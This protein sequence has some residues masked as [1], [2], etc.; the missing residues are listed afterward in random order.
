MLLTSSDN[1]TDIQ[2]GGAFATVQEQQDVVPAPLTDIS[3][4]INNEG[5]EGKEKEDGVDEASSEE[6]RSSDEVSGAGSD[7]E[8]YDVAK[9]NSPSSSIKSS[10]SSSE[11][12]SKSNEN[13]SNSGTQLE[14]VE[15]G[16]DI[17]L[18]Q[19]P[20]QL[21]SQPV[22]QKYEYKPIS[23]IELHFSDEGIE[24][25]FELNAHHH[26]YKMISEKDSLHLHYTLNNWLESNDVACAIDNHTG[27]YTFNIPGRSDQ[28]EFAMYATS[29]IDGHR[30]WLTEHGDNMIVNLN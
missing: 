4:I 14:V 8:E 21:K 24:G 2:F 22:K 28:L 27:E 3:N 6:R 17:Q 18:A 23:W 12:E 10:T 20:I 25:R 30:K 11:S 1:S 5:S 15:S 7:S 29:S 16:S 19:A 26:N 9:S 13:T